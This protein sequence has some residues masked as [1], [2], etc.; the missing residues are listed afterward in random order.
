MIDMSEFLEDQPLGYLL[1][2]VANA[3][4]SEV[5]S[6]VLE[7]LGLAFPQ[8][9]CMRILSK[10]PDRSNAELA[11]DTNV[12]PQAMNMVLRGLE[13]RG[14]VTRP[15]SVSSGRSLPAQLTRE[16]RTVLEKT[17]SGVKAAEERLMV[18]LS[19]RQRADF[20]KMLAALGSEPF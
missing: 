16:G 13:D 14:L 9:I 8:Y 7:P 5:T 18:N 3:L 12:S 2:R 15:A 20:R 11:R 1:H 17:H 19:S 6:T 10:F 4:R